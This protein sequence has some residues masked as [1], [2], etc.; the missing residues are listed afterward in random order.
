MI[1]QIPLDASSLNKS[2]IIQFG[3]GMKGH[4]SSWSKYHPKTL[5]ISYKC[6]PP[7]KKKQ[8]IAKVSGLGV[9]FNYRLY[10]LG[11]KL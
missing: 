9:I 1:K 5:E 7:K 2:H 4:Q 11:S 6:N 10:V 8:N 3:F